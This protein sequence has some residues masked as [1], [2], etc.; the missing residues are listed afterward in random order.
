MTAA[1]K[2][3]SPVKDIDVTTHVIGRDAALGSS[4]PLRDQ[5]PGHELGLLTVI[6]APE[7]EIADR[8]ATTARLRLFMGHFE[9]RRSTAGNTAVPLQRMAFP[10]GPA[11]V[12]NIWHLLPLDDPCE[13]FP[14]EIVELGA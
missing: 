5:P 2:E 10:L 9:G 3:V 6:T 1:V 11:Y 13:P 12:F 14:Y 4:E 8:L 7:Q